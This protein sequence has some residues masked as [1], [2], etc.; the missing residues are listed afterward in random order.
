[1]D[2]LKQ[3]RNRIIVIVTLL[4][5]FGL[6]SAILVN[7][8]T[9]Q[10][11][12]LTH[13]PLPWIVVLLV[14][15]AAL[16]IGVTAY[17]RLHPD[18]APTVPLPSTFKREQEN[19]QRLLERVHDKW[20]K[21]VLE[22]SLYHE[23]EIELGLSERSNALADP[24]H[25]SLYEEGQSARILPSDTHIIDVYNNAKGELLILG[26]PGSGKTTM[27][28][29]LT[30]KLLQI[31]RN[32]TEHLLPIV[33]NLSS[34][35]AKPQ[36]M[37]SWMVEELYMKY[38]IPRP[39]GITWVNDDQILP[40]L[41]GLDEVNVSSREVC[42]EAINDF[43]RDHGSIPT[44]VCSRTIDYFAQTGRLQLQQAV[45][46]LPLEEQQVDKYLKNTGERGSSIYK[47]WQDDEALHKLI[48]TPLLLSILILSYQELP[49]EAEPLTGSS[50]E[51]RQQQLF[52]RYVQRM[53]TRQRIDA[54]YT[55]QQTRRWIT[56]LANQMGQHN[57]TEFYL[58]E[59]QPDW[60]PRAR[61]WQLLSSLLPSLFFLL[62]A[63]LLGNKFSELP[64]TSSGRL[65]IEPIFRLI[66]EPLSRHLFGP[67]F[68]LIAGLLFWRIFSE[69]KDIKLAEIFVWSWDKVKKFLGVIVLIGL[70]VG[71]LFLLVSWLFASLSIGLYF[72]LS[73]GLFVGLLTGLFFGL[74]GHTLEKSRRFKPNQGI[75]R[76]VQN[77]ITIGLSSGLF[78]GLFTGV[79]FA[80][81]YPLEYKLY[82]GLFFALFALLLFGL[83][84]GGLAWIQHSILRLLLWRSGNAPLR[85]IRFLDFATKCVLL[86]KVGGGYIFIHRQLQEYLASLE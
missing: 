69:Q 29:I 86:R 48:T 83:F 15:D 65:I 59:L 12:P 8:M 77:G 11:S 81:R 26:E 84:F 62:I 73:S 7:L 23:A 1:M 40:L 19:R 10:E 60:L 64:L 30:D 82:I 72:G 18:T 74:S 32:D 33:F 51:A 55:E 46:V 20:I 71:L 25:L 52:K 75:R 34:W 57:Q 27:L 38:Q 76:S 14:L 56:W 45:E 44:V 16:L 79:F 24:F 50:P 67:L 6:L 37:T 68:G 3:K 5:F 4:G 66:G 49:V 80:V 47:I 2:L 85:Y 13:L 31:A 43:R 9:G 63:Y 58:E 41:D 28:L 42:I 17:D 35:A 54:P 70:S 53:L 78:V 22:K 61:V 21:G 36:P 39:L